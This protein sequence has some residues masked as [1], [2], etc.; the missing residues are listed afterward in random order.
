M[1]VC[2]VFLYFHGVT[3]ML[4]KFKF[5]NMAPLVLA[6]F[7]TIFII[8]ACGKG[9]P[10]D[11][12]SGDWRADIDDAIGYFENGANIEEILKN[13]SSSSVLGI[14]SG[15]ASSSSNGGN[16]SISSGSNLASS[17]SMPSSNSVESPYILSCE[18]VV[19]TASAEQTVPEKNRPTVTCKEKAP[20]GNLIPLDP[21]HDY[22]WE[23]SPNK[24]LSPEPGVYN[25]IK[26]VVFEDAIACQGLT[27]NC[28]G[29]FRVCEGGC[30]VSSSSAVASSSSS[31]AASSSS[32][33]VGQSSSSSKPSSSSV[34]PSS[35]SSRPSSSSVGQSSSS[36]ATPSSSST[37]GTPISIGETE[38]TLNAGTTYAVTFTGSSG[39]QLVCKF[40]S[41]EP[42]ERV[43]A[44]FNNTEI[45]LPG[46]NTN[47]ALG[48]ASATATVE[49][50]VTG[51]CKRDW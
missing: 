17:S 5:T 19:D 45:K 9:A 23:G 36:S 6:A 22:K 7:V 41:S 38:V 24:W 48:S 42:N 33:S 3:I 18:M 25:N 49:M 35:S 46:Y 32:S 43:V 44:K 12:D 1:Y 34:T 40:D 21:Q 51:K 16:S 31:V 28:E 2:K 10:G 47:V 30:L 14:S 11:I 27:A 29:E 39:S 26:V 20:P 4:K 50:L 37:G 15:V 13:I 8:I